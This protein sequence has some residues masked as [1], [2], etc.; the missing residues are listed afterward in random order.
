MVEKVNEMI[1]E[2][3]KEISVKIGEALVAGHEQ[4]LNFA[5]L[6]EKYIDK[7]LMEK[8]STMEKYLLAVYKKLYVVTF[9]H[10]HKNAEPLMIAFAMID[11]QTKDK[12]AS[13][14][15]LGSFV[16]PFAEELVLKIH[17]ENKE[18]L[19]DEKYWS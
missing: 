12:N 15:F 6:A 4:G 13:G 8:V 9:D 11:E 10:I 16:I 14:K 3:A 17:K 19:D 1:A 5:E 18:I 7:D 2:A